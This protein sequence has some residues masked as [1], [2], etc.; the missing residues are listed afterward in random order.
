MSTVEDLSATIAHWL[1]NEIE[2][3]AIGIDLLADEN[4][5]RDFVISRGSDGQRGLRTAEWYLRQPAGRDEAG[6]LYVKPDDRWEANEVADRCHDVAEELLA[7]LDRAAA[8]P[9][10]TAISPSSSSTSV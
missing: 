6:E 7:T 1:L 4:A 5:R 3:K 9:D 8:D 2:P 10:F